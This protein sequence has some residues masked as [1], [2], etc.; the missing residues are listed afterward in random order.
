[1]RFVLDLYYRAYY[2]ARMVQIHLT[3]V[4]SH[5][6]D[7]WSRMASSA[8]SAGRNAIGHRFSMASAIY[9]PSIDGTRKTINPSTFNLL[10]DEYRQWLVFGTW[11][12]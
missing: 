10:Q 11:Q 4:T 7:E 9:S 12:E 8:Y 3:H 2:R 1:M 6:T 5:E